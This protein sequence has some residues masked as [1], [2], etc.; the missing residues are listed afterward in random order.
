MNRIFKIQLK[1]VISDSQYFIFFILVIL[2]PIITLVRFSKSLSDDISGLFLS[3]YAFLSLLIAMHMTI[4]SMTVTLVVISDKIADRCEFLLANGYCIKKLKYNYANI[5]NISCLTPILLLIIIFFVYSLIAKNIFVKIYLNP[6]FL[7]FIAIII[8]F[9][10]SL[11]R[12]L[13]DICL[14]V[15]K[16][17]R[18]KTIIALCSY[19]FFFIILIPANRMKRVSVNEVMIVFSLVLLIISVI[20]FVISKI[21]S[22]RIN[23]EKVTL[24]FKQ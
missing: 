21:L 13:T 4:C 10:I 24:S 18:L 3:S 15:K 5:I 12:L 6:F 1:D 17:D 7:L 8:L 16:L 14:I 19:S 11:S 20:I 23:N 22:S 2:V 9:S